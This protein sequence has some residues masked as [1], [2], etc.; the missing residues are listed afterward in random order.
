MHIHTASIAW[1]RGDEPFV[2]NRYA[3]AHLWRFDGGAVVR[4]SSSPQ[5]VPAPCSDPAAVDPE[6]AFVAS[7]AS[8]HMLW[9]LSLAAAR[10][11]RV[12]R[13]DDDAQGILDANGEGKQAITV[14]TLRPR[15]A[16]SGERVPSREELGRLH[17]E[18]HE[19]CYIASSVKTEVRCEPVHGSP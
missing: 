10:G 14:V 16:F 1:E 18:A 12:E 19:R 13:Y 11:W 15:V 17:H 9:F 6:E 5:V 8:C 3:R 4:G 2:D 7:L